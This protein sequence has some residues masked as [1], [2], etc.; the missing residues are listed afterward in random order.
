ME[1]DEDIVHDDEDPSH[2]KA[3]RKQAPAPVNQHEDVDAPEVSMPVVEDMDQQSEEEIEEA[4]PL[5]PLPIVERVQLA[6]KELAKTG[7]VGLDNK[8]GLIRSSKLRKRPIPYLECGTQEMDSVCDETF[9][10]QAQLKDHLRTAHGLNTK[11]A[12]EAFALST[13]LNSLRNRIHAANLIQRYGYSEEERPQWGRAPL[14]AILTAESKDKN[15]QT[16][17]F[18][19]LLRKDRARGKFKEETAFIS[20]KQNIDMSKLDIN[21]IVMI[22]TSP[23]R[24][25]FQSHHTVLALMPIYEGGI[26]DFC[27]NPP[28]SKR[29]QRATPAR[30]EVNDLEDDSPAE[31]ELPPEVK[32]QLLLSRL[33][34]LQNQDS[35]PDGD[36]INAIQLQLDALIQLAEEQ[37]IQRE[38]AEAKRRQRQESLRLA[39]N[40][41]QQLARLNT[42]IPQNPQMKDSEESSPPRQHHSDSDGERKWRDKRRVSPHKHSKGRGRPKGL[43]VENGGIE[44]LQRLRT[45]STMRGVPASTAQA[46]LKSMGIKLT[47][48]RK[49]ESSILDNGYKVRDG[50]WKDLLIHTSNL[51]DDC[52]DVLFQGQRMREA[53]LCFGIATS[54]QDIIPDFDLGTLQ[55]DKSIKFYNPHRILDAVA[56]AANVT[57][58]GSRANPIS[59]EDLERGDPLPPPPPPPVCPPPQVSAPYSW[60]TP[61]KVWNKLMH[62]LRGNGKPKRS[63]RS[64]E[65]K[66]SDHWVVE[67]IQGLKMV[68][69]DGER[70][71][72]PLYCVKWVNYAETTWEPAESFDDSTFLTEFKIKNLSIQKVSNSTYEKGQTWL[73]VHWEVSPGAMWD[74]I[75]REDLQDSP[76]ACLLDEHPALSRK[77]STPSIG[78]A[79]AGKSGRKATSSG[80]ARAASSHTASADTPAS[81]S[82]SA[83][84]LIN[85]QAGSLYSHPPDQHGTAFIKSLGPHPDY[86]DPLEQ[87]SEESRFLALVQACAVI[88][89][90]SRPLARLPNMANV[91]TQMQA[92]W[93]Q[94]TDRMADYMGAVTAEFLAE[95]GA[96]SSVH[97]LTCMLLAFVALPGAFLTHKS[98][99]APIQGRLAVQI[100]GHETTFRLGDGVS[101]YK[102]RAAPAPHVDALAADHQ[103]DRINKVAANHV[104]R[105]NGA[106][107]K[108]ILT[109]FGAAPRGPEAID[110]LTKHFPDS[111]VPLNR[112]KPRG[113]QISVSPETCAS[114]MIKKAKRQNCVSGVFG[115]SSDFH[116]LDTGRRRASGRPTLIQQV[117]RLSS[118][119]ASAK[120]HKEA[121]T[122][123]TCTHA[124]ELNKVSEK[125]QRERVEAGQ[126]LATR[127]IAAGAECA[128]TALNCAKASNPFKKVIKRMLPTQLGCGSKDGAATMALQAQILYKKGFAIKQDDKVSAFQRLR[129][130]AIHDSIDREIPEATSLIQAMYGSKSPVFYV[131]FDKERA[132]W[133]A[134]SCHMER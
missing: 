56:K 11:E 39:F 22:H 124:S 59:L 82:L 54:S 127:P 85:Y 27:A 86:C 44:G 5:I 99:L 61:I 77:S 57:T 96:A 123:F 21:Q 83:C 81:Q 8:V 12:E 62:A 119:I 45:P 51:V 34:D 130:Q 3:Q 37:K 13:S 92:D 129:R 60:F 89:V 15:N 84:D 9:L 80:S 111:G 58:V 90:K 120:L 2:A 87:N 17:R 64:K 88:H 32:A 68:K 30:R 76:H 67:E 103:R 102:G 70:N 100:D 101:R 40:K 31:E 106:A 24:P 28:R 19:H 36:E 47:N 117:A 16:I 133:V 91:S 134:C 50:P 74:W 26:L 38:A 75:C 105:G 43:E 18:A 122:I 121:Y 53:W 72:K 131:F 55:N 114:L 107:A 116:V 23:E 63:K 25:S 132:T 52:V 65:S 125:D 49:Q 71:H 113:Q 95:P 110:R 35:D 108:R 1:T 109:S 42:S 4:G 97:R 10:R 128:K 126:G 29:R 93:I 6:R 73:K 48:A 79:S 69:G 78:K 7:L 118:L 94:A 14:P 20:H 41:Y 115:W 66:Q 46:T 112:H 33:H 98:K 104:R